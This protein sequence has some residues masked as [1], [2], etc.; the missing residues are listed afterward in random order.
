LTSI[1]N[2]LP[3]HIKHILMTKRDKKLFSKGKSILI[4]DDNEDEIELQ[5]IRVYLI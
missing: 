1:F 5:F 4:V 2:G 3:Y